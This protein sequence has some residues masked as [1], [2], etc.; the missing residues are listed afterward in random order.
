MTDSL[1]KKYI[2]YIFEMEG[3][4]F[5]PLSRVDAEFTEVERILI[6]KLWREW[7]AQDVS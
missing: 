4:L 2:N 3:N 7:E 5:L 1:F 6:N